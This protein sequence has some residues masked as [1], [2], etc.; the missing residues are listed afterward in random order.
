MIRYLRLYAHFVSFSFSRAMEFRVDFF[1]KI[2]MDLIFYA[3][4][5]LFFRLIYL[6]TPVLGGWDGHQIMLFVSGY[7]V[8][9]AVFMTMFAGNLWMLTM[10][11]NRGDLDYY[12]VRPV[13]S[14]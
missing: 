13:S 14:L 10:F 2:V 6:Q 9:D 12:L 11:I 4:N 5:L 1:F 8:I 7:L 3:V